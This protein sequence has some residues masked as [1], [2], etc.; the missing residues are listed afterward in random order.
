MEKKL[1][2]NNLVI[3]FRTQG[4]K[5]QAV[6]DISFDLY[7]GETL[8]IV[9]ESGSGKS[10]TNR[11][12]IGILAGNAIVESGEII[13]DGKDLLK[14]PEEE[15]HKIRGDKI[16]MIFQDPMSSLNPIMKVGKQLTEAMLLKAGATRRNARKEFNGKLA[17]L[18]RNMNA[19]CGGDANKIEENTRACKTFDEFCINS[20]KLESAYNAIY[21]NTE[22]LKFDIENTLFLISKHQS[23][24]VVKTAKHVSSRILTTVHPDIVVMTD[25]VKSLLAKLNGL[26]KNENPHEFPSEGVDALKALDEILEKA[27]HRKKPNYFTLGYYMMC[28]PDANVDDMDIDELTAMAASGELKDG[29]TL[30]GLLKAKLALG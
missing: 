6:R 27:L 30:A 5:V 26:P 13:Y 22:E 14:I 25:E 1:E 8:A 19:V 9:G 23:V 10:V 11:A 18:N 28:N 2:V 3:S 12:I 29:K 7:K 24:D 15:F 17:E 16:A 20:T 21:K 4:G